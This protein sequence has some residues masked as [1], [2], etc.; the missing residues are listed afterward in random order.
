MDDEFL[1]EV[2][3]WEPPSAEAQDSTLDT[4]TT[5][6]VGAAGDE[7]ASAARVDDKDLLRV[8][9]QPDDKTRQEAHLAS[10]HFDEGTFFSRVDSEEFLLRS[11]SEIGE[12]SPLNAARPADQL[13]PAPAA[14]DIHPI[15]FTVGLVLAVILAWV[16]WPRTTAP[17]AFRSSTHQAVERALEL[18]ADLSADI[19]NE[20]ATADMEIM[21]RACARSAD[22]M[23]RCLDDLQ[24]LS[25]LGNAPRRAIGTCRALQ[26]ALLQ[27]EMAQVPGTECDAV[28]PVH[29]LRS[30]ALDSATADY[31]YNTDR[32]SLDSKSRAGSTAESSAVTTM[33]GRQQQLSA[34]QMSVG[35]AHGI[36]ASLQRQETLARQSS[37]DAQRHHREMQLSAQRAA[38]AAAAT[39]VAD[40]H[41]AAAA[42]GAQLSA[43]AQSLSVFSMLAV[44]A[45]GGLVSPLLAPCT[46]LPHFVPLY[47][48]TRSVRW[49]AKLL[50]AALGLPYECGA[51]TL[52]IQPSCV[53]IGALGAVL[54]ALAATI[55]PGVLLR[56]SAYAAAL[57][58]MLGPTSAAVQDRWGLLAIA[59]VAPFLLTA[60]V[61]LALPYRV[62]DVKRILQAQHSHDDPGALSVQLRSHEVSSGRWWAL[63]PATVAAGGVSLLLAAAM[64]CSADAVGGVSFSS[65]PG[66]LG[67]LA[68][69]EVH[70][71]IADYGSFIAAIV[72]K[73]NV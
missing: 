45:L 16:L 57:V 14:G 2:E 25:R 69:S 10:S 49:P 8:W 21:Q 54:F 15:F 63:L 47:H 50:L 59:G 35:L 3:G 67:L 7:V 19:P 43:A 29:T 12:N 58:L 62:P 48:S 32:L 56:W 11:I 40:H 70:A 37:Q 38:A 39:L 30:L 31:A 24:A 34:S 17:Q 18:L 26:L 73:Q 4:S 9:P 55:L 51:D 22:A 5:A 41:A 64:A 53:L 28:P 1:L 72:W 65:G 23:Q 27:A 61:Q 68:S 52:Q 44:L 42:A 20:E 71:C 36:A 60:T 13:Q 33:G 66:G 6:V 46:C